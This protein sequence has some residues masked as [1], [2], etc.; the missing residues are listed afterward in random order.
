[1]L[2]I[3]LLAMVFVVLVMSL[4]AQVKGV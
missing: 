3:T 4:M 1:V 2:A